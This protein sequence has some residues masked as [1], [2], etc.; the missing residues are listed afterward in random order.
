VPFQP[1]FGTVSKF[2]FVWGNRLPEEVSI[3]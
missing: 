3:T 2:S 1:F